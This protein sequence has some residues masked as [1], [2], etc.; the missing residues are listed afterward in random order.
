MITP[1]ASSNG[2]AAPLKG[3]EI[4]IMT[5]Q[6]VD[7]TVSTVITPSSGIKNHTVTIKTSA[8]VTGV[9]V[10]EIANDPTYTGTWYPLISYDLSTITAA[11]EQM[12]Q[13]SNIAITALRVRITTVV[14]GGSV[15][16]SYL[17]N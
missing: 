10:I 17:G 3:V 8:S 7:E 2:I 1:L 16:A 6:T 14:A 11:H 5:E 15:S 9:V 12:Y 4:A 13:F